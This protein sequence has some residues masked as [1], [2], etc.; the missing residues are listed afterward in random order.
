MQH[1]ECPD[2]HLFLPHA[3]CFGRQFRPSIDDITTPKNVK[4]RKRPLLY[5]IIQTKITMFTAKNNETL[6]YRSVSLGKVRK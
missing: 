4:L 3:T 5:N 6:K 2:V 1:H